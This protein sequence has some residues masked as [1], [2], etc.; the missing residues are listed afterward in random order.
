MH[1]LQVLQALTLVWLQAASAPYVYMPFT[2]QSMHKHSWVTG[3]E[4]P[5]FLASQHGLSEQQ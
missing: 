3:N 5:A 4:V 2:S 1:S